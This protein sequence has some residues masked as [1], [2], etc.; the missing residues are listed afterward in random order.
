[1]KWDFRFTSV[2][3][4]KARELIKAAEAASDSDHD[5]QI[6]AGEVFVGD[7]YSLREDVS[8]CGDKGWG[9]RCYVCEAGTPPL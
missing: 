8:A 6:V 1:M 7:V 5:L 4:A 2:I 3:A 9:K